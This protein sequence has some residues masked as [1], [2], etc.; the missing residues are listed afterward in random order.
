MAGH[1]ILSPSSADRWM[2][3]PASVALSAGIEDTGS[4]AA[5]EG[6]VAHFLAEQCL[7]FKEDAKKYLGTAIAHWRNEVGDH[8]IYAG[9]PNVPADAFRFTIDA[10]MVEGVQVYLDY[11]RDLVAATGGELHVEVE[12]PID[13][14]TSEEGATGTSD[15]V[16]LAGKELIV[17][18]LK[19]GH[20]EVEAIGNRQMRFYGSGALRK[21]RL[22][23]DLDRKS[24]V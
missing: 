9:A 11:V 22:V 2:N 24:V 12:L 5:R 7:N 18:D 21:Y 16:I 15:V 23:E 14:L 8:T 4:D 6:T 3:C 20:R 10:R 13:H 1:A 19:Y 17:V